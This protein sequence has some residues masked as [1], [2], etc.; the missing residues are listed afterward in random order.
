M[1]QV[2]APFSFEHFLS[3]LFTYTGRS[4]RA[5]YWL[6]LLLLLGINLLT[7]GLT[8]ASPELFTGPLMVV[9]IGLWLL[10]AVIGVLASIR[11]LHDRDKS[12]HWLWFFILVPT[13]LNVIG[14]MLMASGDPTMAIGA[15]VFAIAAI[16]ISIWALIE[17]GFLRGT[18]GANRYG[19]D[20]L[21]SA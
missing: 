1:S 11:R 13:L 12:G 5:K 6:A 4:N 7:A 14:N 9:P 19:P 17:M 3:Q 8:F 10:A 2:S 15:I 20:P 21:Q 18:P 16:G